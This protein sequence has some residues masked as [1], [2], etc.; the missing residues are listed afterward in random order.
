MKKLLVTIV[1]ALLSITCLFMVSCSCDS[2]NSVDG[3]YKFNSISAQGHTYNIGDEYDGEVLTADTFVVVVKKDNTFTYTVKFG[4][5][6]M[7]MEGTWKKLDGDNY[8]F[9]AEGEA[10]T[11]TIKNGTATMVSGGITTVFKK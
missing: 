3:T 11:V 8:E 4:Q 2:C 9:T 1:A 5:D 7:T 6:T 10:T